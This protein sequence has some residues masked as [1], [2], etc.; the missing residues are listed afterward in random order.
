[1]ANEQVIANLIVRLSAQTVEMAAGLKRAETEIQS[2]QSRTT[3]TLQKF[4][5]YFAG[6]FSM[7][8]VI[9]GLKRST[10]EAL[11][12]GK[13]M[14]EV[15]T[16][17]PKT[18]D[19]APLTEGAKAAAKLF[20]KA[21][22]EQARAYYQIIS[23]GATN[24][25]EATNILT[26]SNKL[27]V[28][29]VTDV[30]TAA[31]GLTSILNAY[32]I[33]SSRATEVT[34]AMFVAMR[35]GKTTIGELSG[36]IG[37]LAPIASQV[38]VSLDDILAATAALTKGGVATGE[39]M[40]GL[41]GILAAV[42]KQGTE[43][44]D[45][46]KALGIE[47]SAAAIRTKGLSGFIAEVAEKTGGGEEALA[48]LF[49][50]VQALQPVMALGGNAAKD[51]ATILGDMAKKAGET[52]E[53][54]RKMSEGA[55]FKLDQ[56]KASIAVIGIE[57][58]D[59]LLK[60]IV[61]IAQAVVEHIDGIIAVSELLAAVIASRVVTALVLYT[62]QLGVSIVRGLQATAVLAGYSSTALLAAAKLRI[63]GFAANVAAGQL[64]ILAGALRLLGGPIGAII[65]GLTL[66]AAAW[67]LFGQKAEDA[68]EKA[69]DQIHKMVAEYGNIPKPHQAILDA[70][71]KETAALEKESARLRAM[72]ADINANTSAAEAMML[73]M[74]DV[75][76]VANLEDI[77]RQ[78]VANAAKLRKLTDERLALMEKVRKAEAAPEEGKPKPIKVFETPEVLAARHKANLKIAQVMLAEELAVL[79]DSYKQGAID[80]ETYYERRKQIVTQKIREEIALLKKEAG[81]K[82]TKPER[83]EEIRAE[84]FALESAGRTE[85]IRVTREQADAYKALWSAIGEGDLA[86]FVAK[87]NLLMDSLQAQFE[88]GLVSTRD[89]F[90]ERR[91][92]IEEN[93]RAAITNVED[94]IALGMD[95]AAA[96]DAANRIK[97]IRA[98][99]VAD[100]QMVDREEVLQVRV[101]EEEKWRIQQ[102]FAQLKVD[103][104]AGDLERLQAQQE[105]ERVN[106]DR[107]HAE[108]I[109]QIQE[110]KDDLI[111]I[112]GE[113]LTKKEALEQAQHLQFMARMKLQADQERSV[114]LARLQMASQVATGMQDLF[115]TLY[116]SS[117]KKIKAFF[118]LQKAAAIA[119]AVINTAEGVT[120]A[121]AQG[122]IFGPV[123]AGI[124]T[125]TGAAQIALIMAQTFKGMWKGGPVTGGSGTKDDV[126]IMATRGE[127]MQPEPTVR[128]YGVE[129][130]EA[131]R[132][133][134]IPRENLRGF[135][136]FPVARP[137]FAFAE[138]GAVSGR[139]MSTTNNFV[140]VGGVNVSNGDKVLGSKMLKAMEETAIRVMKEHTR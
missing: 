89:Y 88:D 21:P 139:G 92:I 129:V 77:D 8:A 135:G 10:R 97:S 121:L 126:P 104:A 14:E 114:L 73:A 50:R 72:K 36:A 46:A 54:F 5:G 22:T 120:K 51:Y 59:K 116:E 11:E 52:E 43:S 20:G 133:R 83:K 33:E 58:G 68:S 7:L 37:G 65:T 30:R 108:Q 111:A 45:M 23:A 117:G 75:G 34:D 138:G 98:Q 12:F 107:Q 26:A 128:Y 35:A 80:L 123:M 47:F 49:G 90:D 25:T 24:A 86:G 94:Q 71:E 63:L 1:M 109:R 118:Y 27:A 99:L 18:A 64:G 93:A 74:G 13:A 6:A 15:S 100:L 106:L 82:E 137:Q 29:G 136:F 62:A 105:V 55:S 102:Q 70:I 19:M 56:L 134:L 84:V 130:M 4:A 76:A 3:A 41:K 119:N 60:V 2:F 101:S 44:T 32:G 85:I 140:D 79:E 125:A 48:K 40:N 131:I 87:N 95:P 96:E 78:L 91:K 16:L 28:G 110:S 69:I 103:A 66:A 57:F 53:A 31:D 112:D 124:I 132:R 113:Y 127:F 39:A 38:G 122:G 81:S 9:N 61:P 17:L 67:T 115:G 42:L